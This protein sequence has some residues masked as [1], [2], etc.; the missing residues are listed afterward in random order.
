MIHSY[1]TFDSMWSSWWREIW[2][3]FIQIW[4]KSSNKLLKIIL[5]CMFRCDMLPFRDSMSNI[6]NVSF[7]K[8]FIA[9][10]SSV[11]S[12]FNFLSRKFLRFSPENVGTLGRCFHN[13]RIFIQDPRSNFIS[14]VLTQACLDRS[15]NLHYSCSWR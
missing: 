15:A 7:F 6:A 3:R 8:L 4:I 1:P 12:S 14:L 13:M 5:N 10:R 11:L 2:E 9:W